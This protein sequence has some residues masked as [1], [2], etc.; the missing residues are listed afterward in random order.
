LVACIGNVFLGDD[1]FGVEVARRLSRSPL[2]SGAEVIDF[3]IRGLHLAY[4]LLEPIDLVVVV[5]TVSRGGL[6]GT[7]TVIEPELGR[8][9][10][11]LA[12]AEGHGMSLSSAF[13]AA[14]AMRGALPRMLLVGCEPAVLEER[15]E[16]SDPVAAA[17][18]PA[19]ELL[20][21]ILE[22]TCAAEATD[23]KEAD[24]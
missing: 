2:P 10:E 23:W 13:A 3:G 1:G 17:V 22:R 21:S 15:M 19:V 24:P 20:L 9:D 16:L 5:D 14:R 7:L 4:R 12:A 18:G 6:P 11:P 8:N